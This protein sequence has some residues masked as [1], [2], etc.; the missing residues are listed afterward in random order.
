[1]KQERI[2][3]A[4]PYS[5]PDPQIRSERLINLTVAA[6]LLMKQEHLVFSPISHSGLIVELVRDL[7]AEPDF[8]LRQCDTYL[9][10]WSTLL[11]VL[12]IQGAD[13]S[14]GVRHEIDKAKSLNIPILFGTALEK[15]VRDYRAGFNKERGFQGWEELMSRNLLDG[16]CLMP[17]NGV[18]IKKKS[19]YE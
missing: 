1:M 7:P 3:L 12:P 14:I 16:L 9:E 10:H 6:G 17:E 19:A 15:A 11:L 13:E 2:Y 18:Y 5:H 4:G 8:W